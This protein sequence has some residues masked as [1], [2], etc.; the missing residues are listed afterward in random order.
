MSEKRDLPGSF[1]FLWW[2]L[3]SLLA[4][5]CVARAAHGQTHTITK[6][7]LFPDRDEVLIKDVSVDSLGFIWFLTNGEVYRYD[8]YRSL[9]ILKTIA[10]QRL[11]DDMPQRILIDDHHRL[12]MAGNANLSYLDLKTW[13][14]SPVDSALLPP[15]PHRTVAWMK[16]L[17]D[18]TVMVAYE[19]GHLLLI[20]GNKF[21]RITDLHDRGAATNNRISPR[22]AVFWQE[23]YQVG[24][25]AG[26]LLSISADN[27][28]HREYIALRG[29]DRAITHIIKQDSALLLDVFDTG[30]YQVEN[31]GIPVPYVIDKLP[32]SG[33]KR[34]VLAEG[35]AL[36]AYADDEWV[37]LLDSNLHVTQRLSIP[38]TNRFNT[39]VAKVVG[40]EVLL[41]TE[42]GIFVV[43][44]QTS[45]LSHLIPPNPGN[46]KSTRGIYAYPDG[47]LFYCTYNGAGFI[48]SNGGDTLL[49]PNLK[50]AYA[51]LPMNDHQLLIGTDGG[52][53]KLFDR[54]QRTVTDFPYSLAETAVAQHIDNLPSNVMSLAEREDDYLIGSMSGL[55]LLDKTSRQLR[56]YQLASGE[57]HALDLHIR[58]IAQEDN[59]RI[60]LSTNI[61]LLELDQGIL[62]KRYP[63]TGNL[64]VFKSIRDGDTT[65]VA[66]QGNG[67]VAIDTTGTVLHSFGT[68]EG[69]SNNLVFSIERVGDVLVAGTANGLNLL[70]GRQVRH[71][72]M[73]EGLR[74]SEFNSGA[75]FWDAPRNRLYVGGLSGYTVLDME[76]RW[77]ESHKPLETYVTEVHLST[78]GASDRLSDYGWSYRE[79]Y[80]LTLDPDQS[81]TGLYLGMPGNY[82]MNSEIR[83][84]FHNKQWERLEPGQFISLIAPSPGTYALTIETVNTSP[85]GVRKSMSITKKPAYYETGWFKVLVLTGIVLL[86]YGWKRNR[87][88]K[89]R[90]EQQLRNRIAADLHDEVGSSLTRIYFQAG[91][92]AVNDDTASGR[93]LK[94]IS[95][96][97]RQALLSMSDMV[98]SIDS[99]FDTMKEL[100]IRM[101]DYAFKVRNDLQVACRLEVHGEYET[102]AIRQLVRQNLFLIFK[103]AL[104]N[105]VQYGDGSLISIDFYLDKKI[106]LEISNRYRPRPTPGLLDKQGGRGIVSMRQR[107]SKMGGELCIDD[108]DGIFR[109]SV[110]LP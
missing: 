23:Q 108:S 101:K 67:L 104:N 35:D 6:L 36:S 98:W 65:W 5:L 33:N 81:L 71:I 38:S 31:E 18:S 82:R 96:N 10:G 7:K 51:L 61:G 91:A 32:I 84:S 8:G 45:G 19:N 100:V 13:T 64:G 20:D 28:T 25:S 12:W 105:A 80:T 43:Y 58:H 42:E 87:L 75:S 15:L 16:Q 22:S 4:L 21:T 68:A 30:M 97:S 83:Y 53:L 24:T 9:D 27:V 107:A 94:Q 50:H 103:E 78:A 109:L 56:K 41:G 92:L 39:T 85:T 37:Y 70:S 74:Q 73:A 29:L 69:L 11:T 76:E 2:T 90:R 40:D 88:L 48:E 95:I 102:G 26:S 46:N 60:L 49:F 59:G 57:P 44:P 54:R 1:H 93:G 47:A 89:I 52:S 86:M 66:T 79:E 110:T 63:L 17:A 34:Y 62:T 14:V 3:F 77:F 99:Q 55:W 106:R 72:S